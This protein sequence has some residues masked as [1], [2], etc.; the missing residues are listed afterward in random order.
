[1]EGDWLANVDKD[2]SAFLR[3]KEAVE[4]DIMSNET[5][6]VNVAKIHDI[7][8]TVGVLRGMPAMSEDLHDDY[9]M[10]TGEGPIS[11]EDN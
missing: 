2:P 1:M 10:E 11:E 3:F 4:R 6:L 7:T 5:G 8:R 9:E